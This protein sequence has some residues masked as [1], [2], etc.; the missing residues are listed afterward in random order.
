MS[1]EGVSKDVQDR[2]MKARIHHRTKGTVPWP[3]KLSQT[4][5]A[6]DNWNQMF[7]KNL[8]RNITMHQFDAP[9][10]RVLDLGCGCG[11]WILEAAQE[12]KDTQ[13]VGFDIYNKQPDLQRLG[14][15][16]DVIKES[17]LRRISPRV[18]WVHGNMLERLPFED[19][20]FEFVRI[21][22]VALGVPEDEWPDI[23][24]E[25]AR[26]LKPGGVLEIVEDDLIFPTGPGPERRSLFKS[27]S[28]LS[29]PLSFQGDDPSRRSD[30]GDLLTPT[31]TS[32]ISA[33]SNPAPW[34]TSPQLHVDD[35]TLQPTNII[36]PSSL[37]A[38][39]MRQALKAQQRQGS[40]EDLS[41][42]MN[43]QDHTKLKQAW[44]KMLQK[45][46]I[47]ARPLSVIPLFL[48]AEFREVRTHPTL[49][50]P[51]PPN[52]DS[53]TLKDTSSVLSDTEP[54]FI[55]DL[56][57]HSIRKRSVESQTPA[58]DTSSMHSVQSD[59]ATMH[60]WAAMHLARAV[61]VVESCKEAIWQ[62]YRNF[63]LMFPELDK[64]DLRDEFEACWKNWHNDMVDRIGMR[65][66]IGRSVGW[67]LPFEIAQELPDW[68]IWRAR[69]GKVSDS[70]ILKAL[71]TDPAEK[72]HDEDICRCLKGFVAWKAL[73]A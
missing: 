21:C 64:Y 66:K 35:P 24:Q 40:N 55:I 72:D 37:A 51:I 57:A 42:F 6:F 22:N 19:G 45:R 12:W 2:L 41:D 33:V 32:P 30:G 8:C 27:H 71:D 34:N 20:E 69:L 50:V 31:V 15:I 73:D 46:W 63:D 5:L 25:I 16:V 39:T 3:V 59:S 68:R 17:G 4:H 11:L 48:S 67:P 13:F 52:S 61:S 44:Q 49:R 23:F 53:V 29:V 38:S 1:Q 7:M 14:N 54:D 70:D 58:G 36:H 62:E 18:H 28:L 47:S 65:N 56:K 10:S 43:P 9:P 26:I 60:S